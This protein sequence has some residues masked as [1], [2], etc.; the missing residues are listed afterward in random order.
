MA[1]R[2][3]RNFEEELIS[4]LPCGTDE[5]HTGDPVTQTHRPARWRRN[6][7]WASFEAAEDPIH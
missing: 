5:A 7:K 4:V 1:R 6:R 3:M 2:C